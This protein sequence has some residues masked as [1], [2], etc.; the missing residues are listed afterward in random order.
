MMIATGIILT[1]RK[2]GDALGCFRR[3]LDVFTW[4][5]SWCG[6]V[7]NPEITCRAAS[8]INFDAIS[9]FRIPTFVGAQTKSR[10][11]SNFLKLFFVAFVLVANLSIRTLAVINNYTRRRGHVRSRKS[12]SRFTH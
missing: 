11:E 4:N 12:N 5:Q 7:R 6:A 10:M 1:V 2:E 8:M 3:L 9:H